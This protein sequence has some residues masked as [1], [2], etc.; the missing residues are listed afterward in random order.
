MDRLKLQ[1]TVWAETDSDIEDSVQEVY[2]L[3]REGYTSGL[4]KNETSEFTFTT[5]KPS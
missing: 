1:I 3:V 5:T 4:A 2:R